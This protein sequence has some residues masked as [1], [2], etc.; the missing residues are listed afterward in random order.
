M[1]WKICSVWVK[2][3]G[4]Q[5]ETGGQGTDIFKA[6]NEA[7]LGAPEIV[8]GATRTKATGEAGKSR[9]KVNS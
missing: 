2:I 8:R 3:L 9:L 7:T 4:G 6:G 1:C 5:I